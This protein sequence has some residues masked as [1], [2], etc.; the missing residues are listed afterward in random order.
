M[1]FLKEVTKLVKLLHT[2][3]LHLDQSFEGLRNVP[4]IIKEKLQKANEEMLAN[5][6]D[7][8]L[9]EQV[10]IVLFAGDTF[11]QSRTSIRTQ[12]FFMNELKKLENAAIPVVISFGNHDYYIKQ[13]YW[14][15]FPSNVVLFE[16]EKVETVHF[17]TKNQEKVAISGF[18]YENPW[19]NQDML[20]DFPIKNTDVDSHIGIYHGDTTINEQQNYAP[21]SFSEMKI[22]GYDY[23]ALG[24]IHQPQIVSAKP[25][26]VYPG[27]P[28]GHTKKETQLKGVA[29][30][31]VQNGHSTVHF[32]PVATTI[33]QTV[34]YDLT[35]YKTVQEGLNFIIET[36]VSTYGSERHFLLTQVELSGIE[37]LGEEFMIA[38]KNGEFLQYMQESILIQTNQTC[39]VFNVVLK[40][41]H[42]QAKILIPANPELLKKLEQTYLQPTIF[43]DTMKE[44]TKN[45]LFRA[46]ITVDEA[47][48]EQSVLAAHQVI[49]EDF[50]IQEDT[51]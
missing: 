16:K 24:H 38:Y 36:I 50:A 2:A 20:P 43:A 23:W 12:A 5:I 31:Q 42:N 9:K 21:F 4:A 13:R 1:I 11:H 45:P 35:N 27:T 40:E 19:I 26:I 41:Q 25:L 39:F 3:D 6:I 51:L 33:W 8:A 47:W 29:L 32:E 17:M 34:T 10:D 7:L 15:E 48:R 46:A 49:N 37:E 28:Q 18:S 14:F 30:V 44:L 22:K